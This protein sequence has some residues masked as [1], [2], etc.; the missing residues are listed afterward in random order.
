MSILLKRQDEFV[1]LID[2]DNRSFEDKLKFAFTAGVMALCYAM[3]D[4]VPLEDL[5]AEITTMS[6]LDA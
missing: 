5:N 1:K 3:R 4:G 6:G 2:G